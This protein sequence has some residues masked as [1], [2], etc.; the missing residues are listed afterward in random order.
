MPKQE[1]ES[2]HTFEVFCFFED[3]HRIQDQ[4]RQVWK[5]C[6]AGRTPSVI[7][8]A[9]TQSAIAMIRRTEQELCSSVLPE[10][11]TGDNY[12]RLAHLV[13]DQLKESLEPA[14]MLGVDATA[15]D[16][17]TYFPVARALVK[18]IHMSDH[19]WPAPNLP[20]RLEYWDHREK[21][22][23]PVHKK[24]QEDEILLV[25]LLLEFQLPDRMMKSGSIGDMLK[26]GYWGFDPQM[27]ELVHEDISIKTMRLVWM[28]REI[29]VTTVVVGQIML[30]ILDICRLDLRSH[31][32]HL[33]YIRKYTE[34]SLEVQKVPAQPIG[35]L[36]TG[37][38]SIH[39]HP[40]A[41]PMLQEAYK[42]LT[43]IGQP[44]HAMMK[45]SMLQ[46]LGDQ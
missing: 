11:S 37:N 15:F 9:V 28:E 34:A 30:D 12:M 26:E 42:S 1:K 18:I 46:R 21:L 17:L 45:M 40:E 32:G 33:Q 41:F 6:N 4:V 10:G 14:A 27:F 19:S 36:R 16:N 38:G 43:L 3:L 22:D 8:Y 24:L 31:Y 39:W 20:M 25:Q 5:A 13:F 29:S 44:F 23:T 7:A 35:A 2:D